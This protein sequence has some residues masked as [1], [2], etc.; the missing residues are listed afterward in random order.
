MNYTQLTNEKKAQIDILLEQGLSMRRTAKV[1][2]ISHSTISR[3]KA[4]IYKKRQMDISKKYN[5]F[6]NY[7]Y[8][9]YDYKTCSIEICVFKFKKSYLNAHCPSVKQVYNWINE[10]KIKLSKKDLCYKKRRGKKT[11]MMNHTKWNIDHKYIKHY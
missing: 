10:G 7:L 11:S 1:L 6:L 4:G 2:G 3:Y 8:T 9:H 5:I